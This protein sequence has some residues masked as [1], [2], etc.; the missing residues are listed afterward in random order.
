MKEYVDNEDVRIQIWAS[1]FFEGVINILQ[2]L[3]WYGGAS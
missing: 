2:F 1:V 3:L